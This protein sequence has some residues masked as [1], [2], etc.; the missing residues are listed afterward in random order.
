MIASLIM[1]YS[2]IWIERFGSD[3]K[4][5]IINQLVASLCWTFITWNST[6][7]VLRLV[8]LLHGPLGLKLCVWT[9]ILQRSV[10]TIVLLLVNAK[11]T[12]RYAFI[13][14]SK[15]PGAFNDDFWHT[16]VSLWTMMAGGIFQYVIASL[17]NKKLMGVD[18]CMGLPPTQDL[19][20]SMINIGLLILIQTKW[21]RIRG[22]KRNERKR[23]GSRRQREEERMCR[24]RLDESHL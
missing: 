18:V 6:V 2:I 19:E 20:P 13:F 4:R 3:K 23:P 10:T 1:C 9:V 17:P 24:S 14:W 11:S 8:R 22:T 5:T 15:N 21:F 12:I 7:Q 16:F